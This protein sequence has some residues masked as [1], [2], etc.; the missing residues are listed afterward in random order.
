MGQDV[1]VLVE[2]ELFAD[3]HQVA[4]FDDGSTTDLGVL[5][6]DVGDTPLR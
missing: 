3:Y 2:L 6:Q 5:D 1:V 4:V